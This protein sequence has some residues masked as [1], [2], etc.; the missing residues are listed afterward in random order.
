MDILDI[1]FNEIG[2]DLIDEYYEA[3]EN[4]YDDYMSS[5]YL[6]YRDRVV[7]TDVIDKI[8]NYL[9]DGMKVSKAIEKS[10]DEVL[11]DYRERQREVEAI[12]REQA[13]LNRWIEQGGWV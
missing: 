10:V 6:E 4:E 9:R 1:P 13:A 11:F 7:A 3:I 5:Y 8:F 12:L 2:D